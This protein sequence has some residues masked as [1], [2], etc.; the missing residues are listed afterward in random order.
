MACSTPGFLSSPSPGVCSNSCPLS[1]CCYP[2]IASSVVPFSSRP[3]SFPASGS[4]PKSWPLASGDQSSEASVSALAFPMNIQSW[5]PLGL[6]GLSPFSVRD[7][8]EFSPVP[9]FK[10]I[11][12]PALSL[13]YGPTLISIHDYWKSHS[14]MNWIN[15][16]SDKQWNLCNFYL[17][18]NILKIFFQPFRN[19]T[20]HL[21]SGA[22]PKDTAGWYTWWSSIAD[23]WLREA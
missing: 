10:S 20:T 17:S 18:R 1:Q 11:N 9:Q 4:F 7:S 23:L 3:Q 6:T 14:F 2:T 15:N 16:F 8:Q 19:V 21:R 12:S 22:I 13:L 5:F